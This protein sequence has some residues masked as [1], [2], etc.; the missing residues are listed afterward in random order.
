[1]SHYNF[2]RKIFIWRGGAFEAVVETL[3]NLNLLSRS[4][5]LCSGPAGFLLIHK[6]GSSGDG[7]KAY[8]LATHVGDLEGLPGS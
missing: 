4:L 5:G 7:P 1:M 3:G 8:G 2:E 6:L